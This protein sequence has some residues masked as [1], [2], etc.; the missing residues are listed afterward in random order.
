MGA[1]AGR[2]PADDRPVFLAGYPRSGTTLLYRLLADFPEFTSVRT[3]G[4]TAHENAISAFMNPLFDLSAVYRQVW[5]P[6]R[7]VI[8]DERRFD[9]FARRMG[10]GP[11]RALLERT[12][13]RHVFRDAALLEA[14]LDVDSLSVRGRHDPAARPAL[15]RAAMRLSRRRAVVRGFLDLYGEQAGAPRVLEKYP[16][17]YYRLVEL[18]VALPS[19]R[20]VF[21][22]RD[23]RDVFASMVHRARRELAG[24]I[25]IGRVSWMIL[26]PEVFAR[27]WLNALRA[28]R[29]F[30][31][32]EPGRIRLVRYEDLTGAPAATLAALGSFLGL[33]AAGPSSVTPRVNPGHRDQLTGSDLDA[34]RRDCG[35]AL[36]ELGYPARG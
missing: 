1:G 8:R 6:W 22:V 4:D 13:T 14:P 31:A 17:A 32:R 7:A 36:A 27:D 25:P 33:A 20:F 34:I 24:R 5:P 15:R 19:A 29:A 30:A 9:E 12:L 21:L 35:P 28:A 16:F 10:P 3:E 26:S 18:A 2:S 11:A 23:P